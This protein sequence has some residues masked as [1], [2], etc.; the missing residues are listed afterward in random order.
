VCGAEADRVGTEP[1]D[2]GT[3]DA[4]SGGGVRCEVGVHEQGRVPQLG[5]SEDAAGGRVAGAVVLHH[6]PRPARA[7]RIAAPPSTFYICLLD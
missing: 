2:G 5:S 1:H 4:A 6:G 7:L 3:T